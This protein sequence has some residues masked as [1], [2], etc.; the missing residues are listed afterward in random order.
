MKRDKLNVP[1]RLWLNFKFLGYEDRLDFLNNF[2][3]Y[4]IHVPMKH[5]D[6]VEI[7]WC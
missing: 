1:Y 6:D 5:E 3:H 4:I 7:F 2:F